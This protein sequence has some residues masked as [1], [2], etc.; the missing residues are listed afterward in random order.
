MSFRKPLRLP[1]KHPICDDGVF[2]STYNCLVHNIRVSNKRIRRDSAGDSDVQ[3]QVEKD[4]NVST[5]VVEFEATLYKF[6]NP[7][8]PVKLWADG[9]VLKLHAGVVCT[10]R[11]HPKEFETVNC[12]VRIKQWPKDCI[13]HLSATPSDVANFG[14]MIQPSILDANFHGTIEVTIFNFGES[15]FEIEPRQLI[16]H[17]AFVKCTNPVVHNMH[18][19]GTDTE[20][21]HTPPP[22]QPLMDYSAETSSDDEG[23]SQT[24][25][26]FHLQNNVSVFISMYETEN[27]FS[28]KPLVL[29]EIYFRNRRF[30]HAKQNGR[31]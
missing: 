29:F 9:A 7:K 22:T 15:V 30:L 1:T 16:A 17:L 5:D 2:C 27:S 23:S 21:G 26:E 11:V 13:G 8:F 25:F 18:L 3:R 4:K 6:E 31:R 24:L 28:E 10:K 14:I 12:S 20:P 19:R